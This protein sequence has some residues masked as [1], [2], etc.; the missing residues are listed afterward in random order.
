MKDQLSDARSKKNAISRQFTFGIEYDHRGVVGRIV[1]RSMSCHFFMSGFFMRSRVKGNRING[2][3]AEIL[4][5]C[6]RRQMAPG[7]TD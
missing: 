1:I 7:D 5:S 3:F 2:S 4:L 6:R